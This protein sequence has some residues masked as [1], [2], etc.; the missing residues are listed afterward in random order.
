MRNHAPSDLG[1][2]VE[3]GKVVSRGTDFAPPLFGWR[4]RGDLLAMVHPLY[5]PWQPVRGTCP[6]ECAY[7]G[8][9]IVEQTARCCRSSAELTQRY[10]GGPEG[11]LEVAI[12]DSEKPPRF[13][14]A[15]KIPSILTA[16]DGSMYLF[17]CEGAV[18]ICGPGTSPAPGMS[19]RP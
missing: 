2:H 5:R 8:V 13:V 18:S 12:V 9:A 14:T 17:A 3:T 1:L 4:L 16:S 6:P 15:P 11:L 10:F 7:A 19:M